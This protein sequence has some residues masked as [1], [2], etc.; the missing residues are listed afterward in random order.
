MQ[1]SQSLSLK[2]A[3][4]SDET[5]VFGL[6]KHL[7]AAEPQALTRARQIKK[8]LAAGECFLIIQAGLAVGYLLFDY[9][10]F[11]CGWI[12]LMVVDPAYRNRGIGSG[13]LQ[14]ICQKSQHPKVFTSTNRSNR[15]M[16]KA[17]AKAGFTF[18]GEITGLDEGDPELFYYRERESN[19]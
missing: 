10:F 6:D 19:P 13:A 15:P 4:I 2:K 16:Q 8:A 5:L 3:G 11:N 18:A 14:L 1:H 12:E 7:G 9:R 17:L